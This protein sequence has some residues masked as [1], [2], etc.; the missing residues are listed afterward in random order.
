MIGQPSYFFQYVKRTPPP[1]KRFSINAWCGIWELTMLFISHQ[2]WQISSTELVSSNLKSAVLHTNKVI[3]NQHFLQYRSFDSFMKN[4][5]YLHISIFFCLYS[6]CCT[7]SGKVTTS[8]LQA[9]FNRL[10]EAVIS[11][12]KTVGW[13]IHSFWLLQKH[14]WF[15]VPFIYKKKRLYE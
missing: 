5:F 15:S 3:K 9:A 10:L 7:L 6:L 14:L 11:K 13:D 8:F 12:T 4:N 1:H 2:G